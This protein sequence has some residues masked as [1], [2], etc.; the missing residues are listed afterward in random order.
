MG[1]STG[2]AATVDADLLKYFYEQQIANL[3][4][5]SNTYASLHLG[6]VDE[7][8]SWLRAERGVNDASEITNT[9]D[10]KPLL[11]AMVLEKIFAGLGRG[12]AT[13][14]ASYYAGKVVELRRVLPIVT[15]DATHTR[16]GLP[17]CVNVDYGSR[18]PRLGSRPGRQAASSE[19]SGFDL[20]IIDGE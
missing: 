20:R 2:S 19:I 11:V 7:H 14:K 9:T 1:F 13:E 4:R 15:A 12:K 8:I 16:R 5:D 6:V 10:H 3:L 18:F 17:V